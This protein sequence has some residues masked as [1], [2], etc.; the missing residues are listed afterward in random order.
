MSSKALRQW[1]R[2]GLH[3]STTL[4]DTMRRIAYA[5]PARVGAGEPFLLRADWGRAL[6]IFGGVS[7]LSVRSMQRRLSEAVREGLIAIDGRTV[8]LIVP[9][10]VS[11]GVQALRRGCSAAWRALRD[12]VSSYADAAAKLATFWRQDGDKSASSSRHGLRATD[13]DVIEIVESVADGEGTASPA[14]SGGAAVPLSSG[15]SFEAGSVATGRVLRD[16]EWKSPASK[17][18]VTAM[19]QQY[20]IS[21]RGR[22]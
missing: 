20:S 5:M 1:M 13:C 18:R 2:V 19:A 14:P 4:D 21:A 9:G 12:S 3:V 17:A 11:E 10:M 22:L 15:A 7:A 16:D 8:R 6:P